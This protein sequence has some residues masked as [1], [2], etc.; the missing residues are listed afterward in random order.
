M[1]GVAIAIACHAGAIACPARGARLIVIAARPDGISC[2]R[3]LHASI[4]SSMSS[5][6]RRSLPVLCG[7]LTLGAV[8]MGRR[9]CAVRAGRSASFARL[10]Y[11]LYLVHY[12]LVPFAIV[13]GKSQ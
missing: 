11:S 13:I 12:P 3:R 5:R 8:M 1:I 6:N 10:S 4:D 9:T 2:Q 7:L